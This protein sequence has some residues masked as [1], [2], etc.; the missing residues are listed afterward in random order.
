M[1]F[2]VSAAESVTDA[3]AVSEQLQQPAGEA[4]TNS[5]GE[6]A[7]TSDREEEQKEEEVSRNQHVI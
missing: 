1:F 4:T 5:V 3:E 6:N 7:D 2:C